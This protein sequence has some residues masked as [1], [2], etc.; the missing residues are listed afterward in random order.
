MRSMSRKCLGG[1]G[2]VLSCYGGRAPSWPRPRKPLRASQRLARSPPR[3]RR[4]A[5]ADA[6]RCRRPGRSAAS[7]RSTASTNSWLGSLHLNP[8]MSPSPRISSMIAGCGPSA[9]QAAASAAGRCCATWSRKPSARARRRARRCRPP[10]RADC[11]RRSSRACPRPWRCA[12]ASVARHA[13]TR[14]AAAEPLGHRHDVRR[15]AGPFMGEQLAGAAHA[16][17]HLVEH[18]QQ[19]ALVAE[20]AQRP[21]DAPGDLA[22]AA[23]ALH[24][25]DEDRRPSPAPI[26][27]STAL[28][29]AE[30]RP[31]R[32][33]RPAGRSPRDIS[34]GRRRRSSPG[35][36]RGRRPRR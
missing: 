18:Q 3:R 8:S 36:G 30:R 15:D 12:A 17:L 9:R 33:P 10:W 16:A 27:A 1:A 14:K 34:L 2:G 26:A 5:A 23:F 31:G 4:A 11:R 22:H 21:E 13:P 24:R 6:R 7:R 20:L 28:E 19:A 35:C 32:S 25:L 29:I